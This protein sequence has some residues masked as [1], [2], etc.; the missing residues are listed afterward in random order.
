[1]GFIKAA[2]TSLKEVWN[3]GK[4]KEF[5]S[6]PE[7]IDSDV[8][9]IKGTLHTSD[10][11]GVRR[12]S[13]DKTTGLISDG[14][15]IFVPQG[16]VAIAVSNGEILTDMAYL[17]GIYTWD[18][19]K[20]KTLF[21]DDDG[22]FKGLRSSWNQ[23]K[24]RFK[25]GGQVSEQQEIVYIKM[26]PIIGV[27]FGTS[28]GVEFMSP[29]YRNLSIRFFGICDIAVDD[30]VTFFVQIVSR[31][32]GSSGVYRFSEISEVLRKHLPTNIGVA[33]S[34]YAIKEK[35]EIPQMNAILTDVG[36]EI[37]GT[38]T[39]SWSTIYGLGLKSVVIEDISY[40]EKSQKIVEEFDEILRKTSNPNIAQ[41]EAMH[42]HYDV[43]EKMAANEAKGESF[44]ALAGVAMV[45]TMM[46]MMGVAMAQS[47]PNF[48]QNPHVSSQPVTPVQPTQTQNNPVTTVQSQD[49]HSQQNQEDGWNLLKQ[50]M[51]TAS[52]SD[53]NDPLGLLG[54]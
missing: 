21:F 37:A 39:Q 24:E 54:N 49:N 41:Y 33:L 23:F 42:R 9:A 17:P 29:T 40:D 35:Y 10:P 34:K 38:I 53:D 20:N 43:M 22:F 44:N 46:G 32:I 18:T 47:I 11:D 3:D 13:N 19:G 31:K 27:K 36:N 8:I 26:Q 30:P 7:T 16:Y 45:P 2:F 52:N 48:T 5:V 6:I 4:F 12:Q 25:L 50:E 51:E 14:S 1:M 15:H 28:G